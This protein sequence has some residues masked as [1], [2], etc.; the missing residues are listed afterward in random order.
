MKPWGGAS[1][2]AWAQVVAI[3]P[4]LTELQSLYM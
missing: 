4:M 1:A 2:N 3:L